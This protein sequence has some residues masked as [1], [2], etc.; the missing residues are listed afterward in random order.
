[1]KGQAS[2]PNDAIVDCVVEVAQYIYDTYGKFPGT[3]PSIF[4]RYYVQAHRLDID[5]YDKH[6][7]SAS[8]LF[9]IQCHQVDEKT[10][11]HS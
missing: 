2:R 9:A 10:L 6:F 5:F 1:M 4:V 3:V 7:K 11:N 8:Y